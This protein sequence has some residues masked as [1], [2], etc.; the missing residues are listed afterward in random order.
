MTDVPTFASHATPEMAALVVELSKADVSMQR[1]MRRSIRN[2]LFKIRNGDTSGNIDCG[3]K[4]WFELQFRTGMTWND[5]TFSWDVSCKEPL[6]LIGPFE[7]D[8]QVFDGRCD[9]AA[10]THQEK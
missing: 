6:K 2:R 8:G 4:R 1:T 10:F 3:L 9:P 7:W 5:F